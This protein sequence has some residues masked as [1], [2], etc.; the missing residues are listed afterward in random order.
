MSKMN[1]E[2]SQTEISIPVNPDTQTQ[3]TIGVVANT[4]IKDR[5]YVLTVSYADMELL[6]ELNPNWVFSTPLGSI[7]TYLPSSTEGELKALKPLT[8]PPGESALCF[9]R[10]NA[11]TATSTGSA[12]REVYFGKNIDGAKFFEVA[13]YGK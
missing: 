1:W 8:L 4:E 9:S 12:L 10:W 13:G 6:K 11:D 3:I 2:K 7:Y 5:G